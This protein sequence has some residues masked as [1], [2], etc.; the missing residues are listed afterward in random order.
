M[1][2][3]EEHKAERRTRILAAARTLIAARGYDGLTMR[4]LARA[5][6][7]SVPTLYNLFGG[8]GALLHGELEETFGRIVAAMEQTTGASYLARAFT[9]CEAANREL[10][11][12]PRYSRELV[13]LFLASPNTRVL[14]RAMADRYVAMMTENLRRAQAAGELAPWV[15]PATLAPRV[16]GHYMQVMVE[17]A[18]GDLTDD[19]LCTA[20]LYGQGL[21]LLGVAEGRARR[22]LERRVRALQPPVGNAR[23][24]GRAAKRP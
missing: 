17:W 21:L 7:V 14:R 24:T 23:R 4:E 16:Y 13:H 1:S 5:S 11:A 9:G 6:R 10:L 3:F 22:D 20:A 2:L 15:D 19:Q 18:R 8:K 12:V